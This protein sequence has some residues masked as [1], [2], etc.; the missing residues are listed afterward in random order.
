[1]ASDVRVSM[2]ARVTTMRRQDRHQDEPTEE[3]FEKNTKTHHQVMCPFVTKIDSSA[4][5]NQP[6]S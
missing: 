2:S 1:M 4:V 6:E 3:L 5:I